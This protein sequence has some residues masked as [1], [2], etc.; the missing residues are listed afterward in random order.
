M[1]ALDDAKKLA[2]MNPLPHDAQ[3]QMKKI[4]DRASDF[5]KLMIGDLMETVFV[6][7]HSEE[8]YR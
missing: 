3:E 8:Q 4:Y 6:K 2:G 7:L 1:S 5:E